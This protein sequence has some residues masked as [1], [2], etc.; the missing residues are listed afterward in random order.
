MPDSGGWQ[1]QMQILRTQFPG[2]QLISGYRAN[3][4]VAGS[5]KPSNHATGNA[6]DVPPRMDV[7]N[8]IAANYPQ[9]DELIYSPAGARQIYAGAPHVYTGITRANH[10]NHVHWGMK[11]R[12]APTG[13]AVNASLGGD[14][15]AAVNP[16]KGLTDFIGFLQT[17]GLWARVGVAI[18]GALLVII[19]LARLAGQ[20]LPSIGKVASVASRPAIK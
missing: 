14:V 8:W 7:F 11:G 12:S 16:L 1:W 15:L 10:F 5:G 17:P 2:L 18:V 9:S 19:G 3:A 6:V 20:S 4:V 13:N